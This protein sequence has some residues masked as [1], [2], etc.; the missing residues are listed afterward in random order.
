[1]ST[2]DSQHQSG[3]AGSPLAPALARA[4]AGPFIGIA[5]GVEYF[6]SESL[7]SMMSML[8][9]LLYAL[10][11]AL[12]FAFSFICFAHCFGTILRRS[13]LC[14]GPDG[15]VVRLPYSLVLMCG[16]AILLTFCQIAGMLG[17]LSRQSITLVIVLLLLPFVGASQVWDVRHRLGSLLRPF[18]SDRIRLWTFLP[19]FC[20]GIMLAAACSPP[21]WLWDSEFGGYDS[22][23]YHLQLPREWMETGRLAPLAHNVYSYL[24][25]YLEGAYLAIF[26]VMRFKSPDPLAGEGL[27]LIAC[28][29]L[30][31]L[32]ALAAAWV[33]ADL[34]RVLAQRTAAR[35]DIQAAQKGEAPG[36]MLP[37]LGKHEP[38]VRRTPAIAAA[39]LLCTPW[40]IVTGSLAY[41]EPAMLALGAAAMLAA[42]L[43]G[44]TPT[45]RGILVA[46]LLGAA[47][48]VKPTALPMFG[49]P[50]LLLLLVLTPRSE[51]LRWLVAGTLVGI[52]MLLPWTIRNAIATGNPLFPLAPKLLGFGHWTGEQF[53]RFAGAHTFDGSLLDRVRMLVL[54][55]AS[56]PAGVRHRGLLH[57][58][59]GVFAIG[60]LGA[61]FVLLVGKAR[62]RVGV[63]LL[64]GLAA[65]IGLWMFATHLQSRFLMPL[66]V[67]GAV[68]IGLAAD[69]MSKGGLNARFAKAWWFVPIAGAV[70]AGLLVLGQRVPGNATGA[71]WASLLPPDRGSKLA[72]NLPRPADGLL[73]GVGGFTGEPLRESMGAWPDGP[74][75][76]P[77]LLDMLGPPAYTRVALKPG[78]RV[79]LLGDATPLYFPAGVG[80]ATTWDTHP[81]TAAVIAHPNDAAAWIK[82]LQSLGYTHLMFNGSEIARLSKG[83]GAPGSTWW[84]PR[85]SDHD[86]RS[87]LSALPQP[88][89]AWPGEVALFEL[90]DK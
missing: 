79:L 54:P 65:Q 16:L 42:S 11:F 70:I 46:I 81:L 21:G 34:T 20:V 67:P 53:T 63:A 30:T 44:L 26:S 64:A 32:T 78:S 43:P 37:A 35:G 89:R 80:Y 88:I 87:F 86:I 10:A 36:G 55:D 38:D 72:F 59:F 12:P 61:A 39:V 27:P 41:N 58:Q 24:P 33:T 40:L 28:Q 66:L 4:V 84:D 57:P 9:S 48:G 29:L 14:K 31:L 82:S 5:I 25:G 77:E 3:Q 23:S 85:L 13:W 69:A 76:R 52:L 47:A 62:S 73:I 56:D 90:K 8:A 71:T 74:K 68:C 19:G 83:N 7:A 50:T 2:S 17:G 6:C 1:M 75:Q 49:V 18:G 60:V 45:R 51:W 22:L 15:S